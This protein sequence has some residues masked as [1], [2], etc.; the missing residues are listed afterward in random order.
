MALYA[1]KT[2]VYRETDVVVELITKSVNAWPIRS[3][4]ADTS[5]LDLACQAPFRGRR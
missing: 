2:S 5:S 3:A 1:Q 4:L